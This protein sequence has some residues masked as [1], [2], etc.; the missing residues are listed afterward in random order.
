MDNFVPLTRL[1]APKIV[2][3]LC[4]VL[5]SKIGIYRFQNVRSKY[6]SVKFA[7]ICQFNK[8]DIER[9]K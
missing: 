6:K 2:I 9:R 4:K 5:N 1:K 8:I 7:K 3:H